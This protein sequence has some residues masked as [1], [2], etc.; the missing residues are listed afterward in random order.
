MKLKITKVMGQVTLVFIGL[1]I[2][3]QVFAKALNCELKVDYRS[4][5]TLTINFSENSAAGAGISGK[6]TELDGSEGVM[7]NLALIVSPIREG[8]FNV[9]TELE[10]KESSNAKTGKTII[11]MQGNSFY[12]DDESYPISIFN[13]EVSGY[14]VQVSCELLEKK[15]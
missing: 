14:M 11:Q 13:G 9:T 4:V 1:L 8:Y 15:N 7:S 6:Y 12:K 10:I 3:S 2:S 5:E